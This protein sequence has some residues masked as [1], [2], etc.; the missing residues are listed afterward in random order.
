MKC[1]SGPSK[2]LDKAIPVGKKKNIY[3]YILLFFFFFFFMGVFFECY[4]Y[5]VYCMTLESQLKL[6]IDFH[7]VPYN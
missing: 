4:S 7:R 3:I 5:L 2:H 6:E 1:K